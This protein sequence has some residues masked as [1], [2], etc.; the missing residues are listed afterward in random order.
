MRPHNRFTPVEPFP[1]LTAAPTGKAP[2]G[3]RVVAVVLDSLIAAAIAAILGLLGTRMGGIGALLGAG[4][5]LV[6]DGLTL[7]FANRRSVGK[8]LMGLDVVRTDGR[9]M[10]IETSI[11]RNWPLVIGSVLSGLGG[12]VGGSLGAIFGG[13]V[14]GT[15]GLVIG[16]IEAVLVFTDARGRRLGDRTGGTEVIEAAGATGTRF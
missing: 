7:D 12:L 5:M 6:R 11:R 2:L 16:L 1:T 9:P 3:K 13:L 10:D 15:I 8:Q 14:G 4:Y